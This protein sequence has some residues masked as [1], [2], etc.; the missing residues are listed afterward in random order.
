MTFSELLMELVNL[1][2][3]IE[4]SVNKARKEAVAK[5]LD[6]RQTS[7]LETVDTLLR[8]GLQSNSKPCKEV[9]DTK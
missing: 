6:A 2:V 1:Q 5:E 7:L 4:T 9:K 3:Q 8:A